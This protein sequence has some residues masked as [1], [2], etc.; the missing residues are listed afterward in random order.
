MTHPLVLTA[1]GFMY[2]LEFFTDKI[3]GVDTAWDVMHSFIRIP[4]AAVLA[5]A[6]SMEIGPAAQVAAAIIGGGLATGSHLTKASS[7]MLIN[8]SPEPVTNSAAS[9]TEDALVV[10]GLWTAL[11]HPWASFILLLI[12][13]V[14]IIWLLPK[15]L[16]GLRAI[17]RRIRFW[18][19]KEPSRTPDPIAL[20]H[21]QNELECRRKEK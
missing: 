2:A 8:T 11:Y 21:P 13:A 1:S 5:A 20:P 3:P 14:A 18:K 17:W 7:R 6:A 10:A 9:L 19:K 4:A 15:L 16:R 12:L